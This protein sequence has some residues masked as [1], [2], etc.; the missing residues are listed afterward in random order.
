MSPPVAMLMGIAAGVGLGRT[1]TD[2]LG[3]A[4]A[5]GLSLALWLV[6]FVALVREYRR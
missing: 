5:S 4:Y 1:L 3:P 2:W 6:V